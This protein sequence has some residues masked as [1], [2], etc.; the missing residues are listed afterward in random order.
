MEVAKDKMFKAHIV[1]TGVDAEGLEEYWQTL[2]HGN[3]TERH[4]SGVDFD[5]DHFQT[6]VPPYIQMLRELSRKGKEEREMLEEKY[7]NEPKIV[8]GQSSPQ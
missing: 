5:P 4:S 1:P 2:A 6:S 7:K 3:A 8:L